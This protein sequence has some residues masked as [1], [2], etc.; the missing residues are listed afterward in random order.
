MDAVTRQK[1]KWT[2]QLRAVF[3]LRKPQN[4]NNH[5]PP[6]IPPKGI[7]V[8]AILSVEN[9]LRRIPVGGARDGIGAFPLVPLSNIFRT[10]AL[11]NNALVR[12]E[13]NVRHL[14]EL[15]E[16]LVYLEWHLFPADLQHQLRRLSR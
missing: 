15:L 11:D 2:E 9:A 4:A 5:G 1:A 7:S 6:E 3:T 12:L 16:P 13:M 8:N 14:V 10:T